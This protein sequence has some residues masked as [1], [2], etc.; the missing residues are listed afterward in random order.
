MARP[1][2]NRLGETNINIQELS[3]EIINYESST[4]IDVKFKDGYISKGR[5][6]QEF[7]NGMK[8]DQKRFKSE[9]EYDGNHKTLVILFDNCNCD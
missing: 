3:M 8:N 9:E 5:T 4:N 7:K 1:Y 6:Y 2:N